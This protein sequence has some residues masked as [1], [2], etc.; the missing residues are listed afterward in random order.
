[1]KDKL[2]DH[3]YDTSKFITW[4]SNPTVKDKEITRLKE[5]ITGL[6]QIIDSQKQ[7]ANALIKK[8]GKLVDALDKLSRLGNGNMLGNSD[9]NLI[10]Q[11]ALSE[12]GGGE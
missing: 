11:S 2:E 8:N 9:G 1:M 7:T 5:Q 10:A 3:K 4:K 6:S 12:N